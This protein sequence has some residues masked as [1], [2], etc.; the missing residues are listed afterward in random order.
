M[1]IAS[2]GYLAYSRYFKT[3]SDFLTALEQGKSDR[4]IIN[5]PINH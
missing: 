5:F 2:L 3:F 1:A 4:F